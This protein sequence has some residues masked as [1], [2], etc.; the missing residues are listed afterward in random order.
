M[1]YLNLC[2]SVIILIASAFLCHQIIS[3]AAANQKTKNDYAEINHVKYGLLSIDEWMRQI[4]AILVHEIDKLDFSRKNERAL[5]KQ[6]ETLL[7]ILI[8]K[9]DQKIRKDNSTTIGGRITQS[10]IN[11]L[12]DLD[13]IKKGT[14]EYAQAILKEMK[15]GKTEK[16]VKGILKKRLEQYFN[17]T[18][19]NQDTSQLNLIL[20]ETDSKDVAEARIK[21]S[22]EISERNSLIYNQV[23]A[24]IILSL[25]L[26]V[27]SGA[28]PGTISG[29]SK[30]ALSPSGYVFLL[31]SLLILLIAG[32]TTPMIDMEAKISQMN[33]VLMGHP[34]NFEN[35]ILYF[36]SKS[37]LDVFHIM[38][39]HKDMLM[40]F[41]GVLLI[42]FSIIFP[43]LKMAS[44]LAYYFNFRNARKSS[45][46][47]FFV[48]KSGKWSM[49]DVM[50]VAIFMAYVGFNGII[51]SQLGK[52]SSET[53]EIV[54]LTTN[55]TSLQPGFYLFLT[56]TLL[57]LL[58]SEF[59]GKKGK[60]PNQI[61]SKVLAP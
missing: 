22:K 54:L 42:V 23:S 5:K 4:N 31:L 38:I 17:Q 46:I 43:L 57:A 1:K 55:G 24:L 6:I 11:M 21:L 28:K 39:T 33:F 56:Y 53:A 16:Q 35:Q 7:N 34:I 14:P 49:G 27:M 8:D 30:Q 2:L 3:N 13:D 41:V 44:S 25:I 15:K 10:L 9:V 45:L 12:I 47:D 29:V 51:S 61:A 37:I 32:V 58:L 59:L 20:R 60:E 19:N 36:Q 26:F 52:L 50:V 48:F 18:F 40:K